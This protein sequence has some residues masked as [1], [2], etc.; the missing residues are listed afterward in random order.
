MKDF[1]CMFESAEATGHSYSFK[2][3]CEVWPITYTYKK[4][5][6]VMVAACRACKIGGLYS[7]HELCITKKQ[8]LHV[9]DVKTVSWPD[10]QS[11]R[12]WSR[13]QIQFWTVLNSPSLTS[14][15]GR[16]AAYLVQLRR[17]VEGSCVVCVSIR[18]QR[19]WTADDNFVGIECVQPMKPKYCQYE[20]FIGTAVCR[21]PLIADVVNPVVK[22]TIQGVHS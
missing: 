2:K 5:G 6:T 12:M 4:Q 10:F 17:G 11:D 19:L 3:M 15:W 22:Y 8:P 18:T 21:A 14:L 20:G 1:D 13:Y 16:S 9:C 7:I